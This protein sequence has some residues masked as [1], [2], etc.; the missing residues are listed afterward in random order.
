M[1]MVNRKKMLEYL[2]VAFEKA[3]NESNVDRKWELLR[4]AQQNDLI[5]EFLEI[6]KLI[7]GK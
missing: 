3:H 1:T 6:A 7:E 2:K 5:N 4:Q